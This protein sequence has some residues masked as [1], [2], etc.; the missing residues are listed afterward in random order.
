MNA[1]PTTQTEDAR[2]VVL[3]IR[4]GNSIAVTEMKSGDSHLLYLVCSG[5]VDRSTVI[6]TSKGNSSDLGI[7]RNYM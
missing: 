3:C 2:P 7:P 6:I 4:T 5:V 1:Q